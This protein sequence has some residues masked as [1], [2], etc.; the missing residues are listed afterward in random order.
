MSKKNQV[1]PIHLVK[2]LPNIIAR[3]PAVYKSVLAGRK[4]NENQSM[5]TLV[6]DLVVEH[7]GRP[8]IHYLDKTLTYAELNSE[9]N[10]VAHYLQLQGVQRGDVV[11]LLMHNRADYFINFLA[12]AKVGACTALLNH[13]QSGK[14]LAH[15]INLVSPVAA[16]IGEESMSQFDAVRADIFIPEDKIYTVPDDLGAT[17][18]AEM[19]AHYANLIALSAGQSDA[20]LESSKLITRSDHLCYIYTSGTTGMPKAAITSHDRFCGALASVNVIMNLNKNDVFYL[21]L[22][23]YH[24]TG[25]LACWGSV[26]AIGA[27][28]AVRRKFSASEFWDDVDKYQATIFGYVGEMCRYLLNQPPKHSDGRHTLK[29][30]FGN[31][32]RP[33]IW[34]EFKERFKVPTVLEFYGSSEG[35]SRFV[36][37]FNID[38]TIGIGVATLVTYDRDKEG[39]VKGADGFLIPVADGEPGL[40]LGEITSK[41]PF[42]GYT[43]GDKTEKAILRD[44]FKNGDAW[45][46]SGDLLKHVGCAHY[47]FV[48][49]LGDT[50]RWKGE[51]VSTTQVENILSGHPCVADCVVYGVEIPGT[52]GK[53]GMAAITPK[54]GQEIPLKELFDYA[55]KNLPAYA[56]PVF[57]RHKDDVDTTGTFKYKKSDL[58]KESYGVTTCPDPTYVVLPKTKEYVALTEALQADIDGGKCAF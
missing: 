30:M 6:E 13:T 3:I 36:N 31:G 48:D 58:K 20:N 19:P 25:L 8:A 53:A 40:L 4:K 22:P 47:Q 50:F 12:I 42:M 1:R 41:N 49:R 29:K 15:S 45:Y 44:V 2:G 7:S 52:N 18:V 38:N 37:F 55:S 33:G 54:D 56:V 24:A 16:I 43:Q 34:G 35:N 11:A 9:A 14:V 46:D 57:L 17:D 27:S 23:L 51:N 32:L 39:V 26:L 10:K 28:V 21:A 5:A